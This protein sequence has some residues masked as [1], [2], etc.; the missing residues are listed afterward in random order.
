MHTFSIHLSF[1]SLHTHTHRH[2][3]TLTSASLQDTHLIMSALLTHTHTHSHTFW[4]G[5]C[6]PHL[7]TLD[8][9]STP[10]AFW[11]LTLSH[12]HT[13][14]HTHMLMLWLGFSASW[15]LMNCYIWH[16]LRFLILISI[17]RQSFVN[18]VEYNLEKCN[19]VFRNAFYICDIVVGTTVY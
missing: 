11:T 7:I 1:T 13:H 19:F 12:T 2:T 6:C 9:R 16:Y 18:I 8:E 5:L 17:I 15:I 3:H 10:A 4:P 14:T